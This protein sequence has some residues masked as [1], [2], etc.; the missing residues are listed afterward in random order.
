MGIR[1]VGIAALCAAA[2]LGFGA[3]AASAAEVENGNF[4][5]DNLNGW[6]EDFFGPGEWFTYEGPYFGLRSPRFAEVTARRGPVPSV[7]APPQGQFG[8]ISDQGSPSAMFMSQVV[9]LE[10]RMKHKLRFKLAY[11]N[12]ATGAPRG[13]GFQGFHTPK[14]FRFGKAA[15]P[16]QQFRMDV[17]KPG[18]AIRS[19]KKNA[20]LDRVYRTERGDP[21]RRGFRTITADLSEYAGDRVRLRFAVVVTEAPLHVGIDAVKIRSKDAG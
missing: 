16:N 21:N 14:S 11:S 20:V 10:R 15:R 17:M 1:T 12:Q 2:A 8:A 7:P 18:A 5:S 3:T 13:M 9:K 19:L 6:Q 4:E